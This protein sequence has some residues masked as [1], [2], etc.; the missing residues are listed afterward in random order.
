M[1][2]VSPVAVRRLEIYA[3]NKY[4]Q[5][6]G[7]PDSLLEYD[8]QTDQLKTVVLNEKEEHKDGYRAFVVE[9]AYKNEI[10]E[11]MEVVLEGKKQLYGFE[12]D[13]KILKLI[14]QVEA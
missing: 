13:Y 3:E 1:D 5:W 10:R 9:N 14:D 11:F 12:E 7:T 8:A 6:S 2:V 4:L